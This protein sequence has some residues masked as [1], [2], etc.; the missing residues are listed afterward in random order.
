M[1]EKPQ[2]KITVAAK[3][4]CSFHSWQPKCD[5]IRKYNLF[6]LFNLIWIIFIEMAS[7]QT[8]WASELANLSDE[9]HPQADNQL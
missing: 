5:G 8:I 1:L 2:K 3:E 9:S 6:E 7:G 4:H